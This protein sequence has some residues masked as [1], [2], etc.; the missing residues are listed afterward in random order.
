MPNR[1]I[2]E[3]IL[4]SERV[5]SLPSWASEV[6]YR[7]LMNVVDDFGRYYANSSLLRA[8]CYPLK[9]DKVSNADI[10]KWLADC[11]GAGLVSTYDSGG[12]RYLQML[13]FRQQERA[14]ASKFPQ[15]PSEC[16]A[17]AQQMIAPAHLDV[18]VG[19]SVFE[20]DSARKA[21]KRPKT[22][23]PADFGLSQRVVNWANSNGYGRL[24]EHLDSFRLKAAAHDYRYSDWDSAFMAAIKADWAGLNGKPPP[25]DKFAGA[26]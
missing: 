8:A 19:V 20:G 24:Q 16:I 3:G 15:A 2:R 21:R 14:K 22:P 26:M 18:D 10:D 11:A 13:D 17:H 6:F 1:I 9:I 7:R 25:A 4:T 23:I 12:R 5:D